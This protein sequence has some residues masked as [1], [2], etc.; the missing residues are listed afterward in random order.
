MTKRDGAAFAH[1]A[2][3]LSVYSQIPASSAFSSAEIA[4]KLLM[5]V[6]SVKL[7]VSELK[8]ADPT[9]AFSASQPTLSSTVWN[10]IFDASEQLDSAHKPISALPDKVAQFVAALGADGWKPHNF[11][12]LSVARM[13]DEDF[14]K[15]VLESIAPNYI[16]DANFRHALENGALKIERAENTELMGT[17]K[18]YDVDLYRGGE[19]LGG[20]GTSSGELNKAYIQDLRAKGL[21][22]SYGYI[23]DQWYLAT[24]PDEGSSA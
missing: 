20:A 11:G 7:P 2:D 5:P 1:E 21:S 13:S 4:L 19:Y 22:S 14:R 9:R 24:W 16:G 10:A 17:F 12:E 8:P 15:T 23:N 6:P 18:S 3:M